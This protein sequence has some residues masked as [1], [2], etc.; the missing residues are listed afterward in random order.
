MMN[1][2]LHL[3]QLH[4]QNLSNDSQGW[5]KPNWRLSASEVSFVDRV[6]L[7]NINQEYY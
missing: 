5:T 7:Y 3:Y 6:S 2:Q 1:L 4:A